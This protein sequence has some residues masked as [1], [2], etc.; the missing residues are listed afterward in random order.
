MVLHVADGSDNIT[1][2]AYINKIKVIA[3]VCRSY[4]IKLY[5]TAD[6]TLPN[7]SLS[8]ST[9]NANGERPEKWWKDRMKNLYREIPDLGGF[10]IETAN[11]PIGNTEL[12]QA[13]INMKANI[14]AEAIAPYNGIV[15]ISRN[16]TAPQSLIFNDTND[17]D[18]LKSNITSQHKNALILLKNEYDGFSPTTTFI[19]ALASRTDNNLIIQIQSTLATDNDSTNS[20]N[21]AQDFKRLISTTSMSK[22]RGVMF[23]YDA[24]NNENYTNSIQLQKE[25][26]LF[27]RMIWRSNAPLADIEKEWSRLTATQAAKQ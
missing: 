16:V 27:A 22:I 3:N 5:L 23:R 13:E 26:H 2:Q 19:P 15:I 17:I 14:L 11:N 21:Y 24:D 12:M 18:N 7:T 6:L 10:A 8:L 4:A 1:S 20:I 9:I 25:L